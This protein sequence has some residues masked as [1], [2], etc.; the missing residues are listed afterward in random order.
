METGELSQ[1]NVAT[2]YRVSR[3]VDLAPRIGADSFIK[4][5]THGAQER[6]SLVLLHGALEQAFNLLVEEA[7]RRKCAVH[8]VSAWQMFQAVDSIR[9]RHDP[10]S[11]VNQI[12]M[13]VAG[14][15]PVVNGDSAVGRNAV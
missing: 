12:A 9:Q 8:F 3:W 1:G 13:P 4:L 15:F 2:P 10:V 6:H 7:N 5:Y 11:P 14:K